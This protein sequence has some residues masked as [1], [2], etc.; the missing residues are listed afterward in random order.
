MA[1][2]KQLVVCVRNDG[3]EASLEVRKTCAALGDHT[4]EKHGLLRIIDESGQDYLYPKAFFSELT[5]R[6]HPGRR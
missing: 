3:Y 4:A 1:K 6:R 2:A 5:R